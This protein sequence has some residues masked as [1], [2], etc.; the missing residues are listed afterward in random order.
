M[1]IKEDKLSFL[2]KYR[3]L[4]LTTLLKYIKNKEQ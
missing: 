1:W 3:K 2:E 4:C